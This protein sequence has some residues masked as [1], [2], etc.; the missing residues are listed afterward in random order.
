M[1]QVQSLRWRLTLAMLLVFVLG[2]GAAAIFS[3]WEVSRAEERAHER[4]LQ[5]QARELLAALRTTAGRAAAIVLPPGREEA[6]R[7]PDTLFAYTLYDA[8]QRPIALSPNLA[9]PLPYLEVSGQNDFGPL[10]TLNPARRAALAARAPDGY[11]LVVARNLLDEETHAKIFLDELSEF[12]LVFVPFGVISLAL[13]W[14]IG[15]WSLRPLARA[16]R[17]AMTIGSANPSG[18]ISLD[19]LP[20]EIRTLVNA[21]NGALERLDRAYTAQRRFTAD[22]AHELR[23]PLAVLSLRLQQAKLEAAVDWPVVERDLAQMGRLIAQLMDLARKE[24]PA[25]VEDPTG[26]CPLNLSRLVR[27]AAAIMLPL[28]EQ[29]GRPLEVEAPDIV[30]VH[31]RPD[32][33]RDAIR[34]LLDN[35]LVHGEGT[36]RVRVGE[37]SDHA[38]RQVLVEVVDQG[39][40]IPDELKEAVFDRFRKAVLTSP[41]A[42]LGLAIVRQ[43]VRAHGG[44]VC[45]WP[46]PG[47]SIRISLPAPA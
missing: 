14:L 21:V 35:A 38:D 45:V 40:G 29:G 32:D 36:V 23:T 11:M 43:V 25:R 20:H 4:S 3:I 22:A 37:D 5:N 17:E 42:G 44:E 10:Q 30:P 47:C 1:R 27:E 26:L 7:R 34:N 46:G 33:L 6:F 19:G 2:L 41:G 28:A 24:D 39:M 13:I 16:S 9:K 12:S 15:G 31:G 18:R 8:A